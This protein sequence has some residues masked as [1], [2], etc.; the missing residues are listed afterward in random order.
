MEHPFLQSTRSLLYFAFAWAFFIL[1]HTTFLHFYWGVDLM[2]AV[3]DALV[4]NLLFAALSF[5][6]WYALIPSKE[7]STLSMWINMFTLGV[8][9]VVAWS[10]AVQFIAEQIAPIGSDYA[11][12]LETR[13]TW[14]FV[15]ATLYFDDTVLFYLITRYYRGQQEKIERVKELSAMLEQAEFKALKSQI[16]PHFLFNSLN[17]ISSLILLEPSKAHTMIIQL[18]EYLR[19]SVSSGKKQ[20]ASLSEEL[21]NVRQYLAIEQT[22]FGKR[23]NVRYEI[24]PHSLEMQLPSLILQPLAENAIKHGVHDSTQTVEILVSSC[25]DGD[26]LILQISNTLGDSHPVSPTGTGTGIK[27]IRGRLALLYG[28]RAQLDCIK[29]PLSFTATLIIPC[30]EQIESD[31]SR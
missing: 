5:G 2:Y 11:G 30:N 3:I 21:A 24:D 6:L 22:R 12:F 7:M 10:H 23:L 15:Q 17:S 29:E 4:A 14:R 19:Y 26:T 18:S 27:N 31:N 20:L 9:S 1:F 13:K 28:E 8:V 25:K 16:N